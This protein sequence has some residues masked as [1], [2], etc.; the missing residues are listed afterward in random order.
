MTMK[1]ALLLLLGICSFQIHASDKPDPEKIEQ[2]LDNTVESFISNI[3]IEDSC[4]KIA[5][6]ME[7]IEENI[8]HE[9]N[10]D[11]SYH[12]TDAEKARLQKL[13]DE[14]TALRKVMNILGADP[15]EKMTSVEF[16]LA[17]EYLKAEITHLER[18]VGC[19]KMAKVVLGNYL[20]YYFIND[21][22]SEHKISYQCKPDENTTFFA[23]NSRI[24][25]N[26]MKLFQSNLH[27]EDETLKSA[28]SIIEVECN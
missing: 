2:R 24:A 3:A 19:V 10:L 6:R 22:N 25:P 28:A 8:E 15:F 9:L 7:R 12:Y 17:N 23:V 1:Y 16:E 5:R 14:A 18:T 20:G 13:L 4:K 27:Y 26:E 11:W 21:D